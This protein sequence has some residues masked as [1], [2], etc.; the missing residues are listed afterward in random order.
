[1][2]FRRPDRQEAFFVPGA[3]AFRVLG[4]GTA[5]PV[6]AVLAAGCFSAAGALLQAGGLV[7]VRARAPE[8]RRSGPGL[9]PC[10]WRS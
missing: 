6:E 5:G 1:M 3:H 8:E 10:R 9:R 2:A 4:Y 7:Y